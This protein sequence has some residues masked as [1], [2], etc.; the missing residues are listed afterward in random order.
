MIVVSDTTA[1][2]NLIQIGELELLKALYQEIIIPQAVYDEL[3]VLAEFD[4]PIDEICNQEWIKVREVDSQEVVEML[5]ARL[6]RGEAEAIA[7]AIEVKAH[8]MLI[9]EKEGRAVAKENQIEVVGT[10]GILINGKK[11]GFIDGIKEK[12]DE[13]REIGFWISD[14]LYHRIIEIERRM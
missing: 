1:I 14:A 2:S 11:S 4:V 8:Y 9:D 6:D 5:Q 7:L 13:L 10:I 3:L 12:M